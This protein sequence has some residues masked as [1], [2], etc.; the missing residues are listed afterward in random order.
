MNTKKIHKNFLFFLIGLLLTFLVPNYANGALVFTFEAA[1]VQNTTVQPG[2]Y[3]VET[4]DNL[5]LGAKSGTSARFESAIGSFSGS[6]TVKSADQY[7]GAGGNTRYIYANNTNLLLDF[8]QKNPTGIGYFGFWWSAGSRANSLEIT[9]VDGKVHRY[10]TRTI[11]ESPFLT[12]QHFGNP[13]NPF[14][15]HNIGEPYVFLNFFATDD[16]SKIKYVNMSGSNFESDNYTTAVNRQ[17][18]TGDPAEPGTC[19]APQSAGTYPN[20]SCPF[21]KILNMD[22]SACITPVFPTVNL[23]TT[24]NTKPT[25]KGTIGGIDS[26]SPTPLAGSDEFSV[27]VNGVRYSTTSTALTSTQTSGKLTV[28][29]TTW[30]LQFLTPLTAKK[31]YEVIAT[32]NGILVDQT[33]NELV[34]S[35]ICNRP[36]MLNSE[37]TDCITPPANNIT[38][39]HSGNGVNYAKV[40]IPSS[41]LN[42][43][44]NHQ[45]DVRADGSGRCPDAPKDKACTAV[46]QPFPAGAQTDGKKVTICHFPPGNRD[47]VQMISISVNALAVHV[48]HH[49][50]TIWEVGKSCPK[51]I[52][53]CDN[54]NDTTLTNPTVDFLTTTESMPTLTGTIGNLPATSSTVFS[55]LVD[56]KTYTYST[57]PGGQVQSNGITI[58]GTDWSLQTTKSI[59]PGNYEVVAT[60]TETPEKNKPSTIL[61]DEQA[62]ELTILPA[63]KETEAVINGICVPLPTVVIKQID[64]KSYDGTNRV[65]T[66][67]SKP[68]IKGIVGDKPLGADEDFT[69]IVNNVPYSKKAGKVNVDNMNWTLT[70][71]VDLPIGIYDIV[72]DRDNG[73]G[74]T[75]HD[76]MEITPPVPTVIDNKDGYDTTPTIKGTVG[77][78]DLAPNDVFSVTVK[79]GSKDAVIGFTQ[80]VYTYKT[81]AALTV[82]GKNWELT[83]PDN[84]ALEPATYEIEAVR[85]TMKDE[86]SDEL[87]IK[88]QCRATET[89]INGICKSNS[90]FPTVRFLE[91]ADTMPRLEGTV[92]ASPLADA[93]T[94]TVEVAGTGQIYSKASGAV[95]VDNAG[96]WTVDVTTPLAVNTYDI[97]ATRDE[98]LKDKTSNELKIIPCVEPKKLKDGKCITES[99]TPTV[100]KLVTDVNAAKIEVTGTVGDVVLSSNETFTVT[101]H[102]AQHSNVS[103]TLHRPT[104]TEWTC[105]LSKPF[106]A[107][108]FDVDAKRGNVLDETSG[109]LEISGAKCCIGGVTQTCPEFISPPDRRAACESDG[110]TL[111]TKVQILPSRPDAKTPEMVKNSD[112]LCEDGGKLSYDTAITGATIKRA[113]IANAITEKPTFKG[114]LAGKRLIIGDLTAGSYSTQGCAEEDYCDG[115]TITNATLTDAMID[116]D[117]DYIDST[118]KVIDESN[119]GIAVIN[120][121]TKPTYTNRNGETKNSVIT[122]GI[123]TAGTA[124]NQP[125]RGLVTNGIFVSDIDNLVNNPNS[126]TTKGR[127]ADK[128]TLTNV[129]ITNAAITTDKNGKTVVGC[130]TFLHPTCAIATISEWKTDSAVSGDEAF[131]YGTVVNAVLKNATLGESN[132]CFSSGSVGNKGQL[133]WKEVVK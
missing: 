44:E 62:K 121:T 118:G 61:V 18:I 90:E 58:T 70:M 60:R 82:N 67:N 47:N 120:G 129:T 72:A 78:I 124:N 9:T 87:V 22:G 51:T 117:P 105:A 39:C 98:V 25:I 3:N 49:Y 32:R 59:D 110:G 68:V 13:N 71:P 103:C 73:L 38:L 131:V 119:Q 133:N 36:Q 111:P 106:I 102:N 91:T 26:T 104:T 17:P 127:E 48:G 53:D 65:K 6:Y 114:S 96:V 28:S 80:Q 35:P 8:T 4:F 23:L 116:I 21:P 85:G 64:G 112:G 15:G 86:S 126:V 115:R 81:D 29:G 77:T 89:L 125:V 95:H 75:T 132:H 122:S 40:S 41:G 79:A 57:N 97:I 30:S 27:V 84:K 54:P 130:D 24:S 88:T 33:N 20:C 76:E 7:G 19:T 109:E 128:I 14:K 31:T 10:T 52:D 12:Q 92:G 94:F 55:V 43:H 5:S 69:V 37:G 101:I 34:I 66:G 56:G 113:R 107:G 2:E 1:G 42:G 45:Y 100:N 63:C 11:L 16:A 50:D 99:R 123:I 83:I 74:D 46:G 108:I 93:E